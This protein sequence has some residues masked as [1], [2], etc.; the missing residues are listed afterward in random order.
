MADFSE[1]DLTAFCGLYCEDC[2]RFQSQAASLA[3][4]LLKALDQEGYGVYAAAKAG[5]DPARI[6]GVEAYAGYDQALALLEALVDGRCDSPCRLGGDGCSD[7]CPVKD[8]C[9]QRGLE[10]CW[11]CGDFN[12]C[13]KA[14]FL[15]PISGTYPKQNVCIIE[16][17]GLDGWSARRCRFYKWQ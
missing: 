2:I 5:G 1:K 13:A 15:E 17:D 14:D 10:G 3:E 8:C 6:K 9:L 12:K 4:K 11:Q 16:K 7:N